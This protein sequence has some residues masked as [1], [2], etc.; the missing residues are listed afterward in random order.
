MRHSLDAAFG[1]QL[2]TLVTSEHT[3]QKNR[4]RLTTKRVRIRAR[5]VAEQLV[6]ERRGPAADVHV[7]DGFDEERPLADA[8]ALHLPP[9]LV[10]LS[11][12]QP[13]LSVAV[14]VDVGAPGVR[15]GLDADREAGGGRGD[16][17]GSEVDDD[18]PGGVKPLQGA[19]RATQIHLLHIP[20]VALVHQTAERKERGRLSAKLFELVPSRKVVTVGKGLRQ[21]AR[22]RDRIPPKALTADCKTVCLRGSRAR[23]TNVTSAP[24]RTSPQDHTVLPELSPNELLAFCLWEDFGS[25]KG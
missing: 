18:G 2:F 25:R 21:T 14:Q 19:L 13:Q 24:A 10:L 3:K 7:R 22:T 8:E 1:T 23:A 17:V 15:G 4:F 6:L 11:Q 12:Q 9:G 20:G 5:P 16:G